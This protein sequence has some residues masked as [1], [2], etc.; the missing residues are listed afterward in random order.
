LRLSPV[1]VAEAILPAVERL[2]PMAE[3]NGL[4]LSTAIPEDLPPVL[5][6]ATRVQQVITN[7]V[8]NAIKFTPAPGSITV[9]ATLHRDEDS[10]V[11]KVRDTGVGIPEIDLSR[12]FERFYKA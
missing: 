7:L 12:I 3:R 4:Q 1:S 10:V 5:V 6:D 11:V 2:Q 8:H 9:S